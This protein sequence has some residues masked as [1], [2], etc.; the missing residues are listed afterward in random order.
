MGMVSE[1]MTSNENGSQK[2]FPNEWKKWNQ[3]KRINIT[4]TTLKSLARSKSVVDCYI[5][6]NEDKTI[7]DAI[8]LSDQFW[9]DGS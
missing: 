2:Y 7:L 3:Q 5:W 6:I 9:N 8:L 1:F 4:S